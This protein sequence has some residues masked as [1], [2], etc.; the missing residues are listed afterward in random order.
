MVR[1]HA[2]ARHGLRVILMKAGQFDKLSDYRAP[3]QTIC[4]VA[5]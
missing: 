3:M 4:Q 2:Q 5:L 1:R